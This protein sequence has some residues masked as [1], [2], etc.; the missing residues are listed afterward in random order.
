MAEQ[1]RHSLSY[2]KFAYATRNDII[3]AFKKR[4]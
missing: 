4:D 3:R 2:K 1:Q